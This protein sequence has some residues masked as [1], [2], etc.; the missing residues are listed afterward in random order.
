MYIQYQGCFSSKSVVYLIY[1]NF[2]I[3]DDEFLRLM[4]SSVFHNWQ[5]DARLPNSAEVLVFILHSKILCNN[6]TNKNTA[7]EER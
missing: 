7:S 6:N 2:L 4:K 3:V 1:F 5:L